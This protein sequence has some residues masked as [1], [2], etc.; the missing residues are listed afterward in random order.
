MFGR[1]DVE[2]FEL[3]GFD[4]AGKAI[5][6]LQDTRLMFVGAPEGKH[7]EIAKRLTG[8][9]VP[10]SRLRV[11]GFVEDRESFR[12][13][14]QEVD[15]AVM[16]SRT[17]GFGLTGLK[18]MSAGLPVLVSGN[19][20]FGKALN[21]VPFGSSFVVNSE[22]PADWKEAIQKIWAKDRKRR[23]E[24]VER[25]RDSY[26]RKYNWSDQIKE[27]LKKMTT[28][29]FGRNVNLFFSSIL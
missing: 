12:S 5:A 23:L 8:C 4:I 20:G 17:E 13:L 26:Y 19:S 15:L 2:D 25:L 14:F 7:K 6:A 1:G 3:K 24:E 22:D 21:S 9:G 27:F 16:P 10:A 29:A 11:R 18:A 28:L